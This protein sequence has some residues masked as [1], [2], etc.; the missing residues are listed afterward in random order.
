MPDSTPS[1]LETLP[2]DV[3]Y[4]WH[5]VNDSVN[6][7]HF[8]GA[9]VQWGELD[10]NVDEDGKQLILRHD[11]YRDT[12]HW[13]GEQ[14]LKV[15][16]VLPRLLFYGKSVKLDFKVGD[17]VLERVLT[18]L[19]QNGVPPIR[20]WFN[21]DFD[22]L[23]DYWIRQLAGRFPFAVIQVPLNS[24]LPRTQLTP[25]G[26]TAARP[27]LQELRQWGITRWS[28][29]MSYGDVP[30]LVALLNAWGHEVNIYGIENL[31]EFLA[32]VPLK[33][34]A[35][36]AD[37]NFPEWGLF[38]RGSGHHGHFHAFPAIPPG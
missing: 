20:L 33:P 13:P 31:S 30:G 14:P 26:L 27:R 11:S 23:G 24:V 10:I 28:V 37:F 35:I 21:A 6:M 38:G 34:T 32:V 8:L 36:T 29:G 17:S 5:G 16:D 19:E 22:L 12:P 2:P 25:A 9:P 15:L 7:R 4:V 1:S 3:T 18:W